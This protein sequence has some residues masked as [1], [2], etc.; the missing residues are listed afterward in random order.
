MVSLFSTLYR[1]NL[2]KVEKYLVYQYFALCSY[3]HMA[4]AQ[5]LGAMYQHGN[6]HQMHTYSGKGRQ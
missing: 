2:S 5:V 4:R 3:T 1:T 6:G